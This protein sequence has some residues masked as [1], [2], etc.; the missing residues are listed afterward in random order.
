MQMSC[1][2]TFGQP[3]VSPISQARF[4]A[5]ACPDFHFLAGPLAPAADRCRNLRYA[6]QIARFYFGWFHSRGNGTRRRIVDRHVT[7]RKEEG[8]YDPHDQISPG[9]VTCTHRT[10]P[11]TFQFMSS[12]LR[13]VHARVSAFRPFRVGTKGASDCAEDIACAVWKR[14]GV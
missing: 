8:P 10:R 11:V 12:R 5:T 3:L 4:L 1:Q 2:T 6:A 13:I 7:D 9:I 14:G